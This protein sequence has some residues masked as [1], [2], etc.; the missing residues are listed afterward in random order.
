ML[1]KTIFSAILIVFVLLPVKAFSLIYVGIGGDYIIPLA[2]LNDVNLETYGFNLQLESRNFCKL[3]YGLRFDYI[4][5]DKK[6]PVKDDYYESMLLIS[7]KVR[8]NFLSNNCT[9]Y[10]GK[11]APYLQGMLT[12]SSIDGSDKKNL[13]GFGGAAGGGIALG[14]QLFK[15]CMMF[16]L[17]ALYSAPNFIARASGR[18]SLQMINFNIS[19]SMG[20]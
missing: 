15:T 7:P 14:F 2:K 1:K 11:I 13:M 19:L 9:D 18:P 8:Y 16:D 5:L 12:I 4:W 20:L 3:W 17:N 6:L 10:T